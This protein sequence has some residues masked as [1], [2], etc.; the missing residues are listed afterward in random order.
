MCDAIRSLSIS[1]SS[2]V[3]RM[4]SSTGKFPFPDGGFDGVK[5][6]KNVS[7]D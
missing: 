4:A 3:S 7:V 2:I 6:E 5:A 1:K